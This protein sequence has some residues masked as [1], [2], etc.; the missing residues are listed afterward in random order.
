M[1]AVTYRLRL[2]IGWL[3]VRGHPRNLWEATRFYASGLYN[4]VDQHHIFLNASG[5]A[6]SLFICIMPMVL[7]IFAI[8]GEILAR[9][10]ITQQVHTLIDNAIPYEEYAEFVKNL[11]T[12]RVQEFRQYK[13]EAGFIGFIGLAIASTGLFSGM[14]TVLNTIYNVKTSQSFL[15]AKLR[16]IV[17]VVIVM[18]FVLLATTVI[19]SL[20]VVADAAQAIPLLGDIPTWVSAGLPFD[21]MSLAAI[22]L[23]FLFLYGALPQARQPKS[24]VLVSAIAAAILWTIAKEAF[25]IYLSRVVTLKRVYGAYSLLVVTGF[26]IYYTSIVFI[27]AAEIG[28]LFTERKRILQERS[29]PPS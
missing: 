1:N 8:L 25:G 24:T 23:A 3:R 12:D 16:D 29:V 4:R 9:T 15:V 2:I 26:W 19:P 6:F 10:S 18:I 28:Q 11:I 7:I 5:L 20:E 22:F 27:L 13:R 14:R 17:L 21:L